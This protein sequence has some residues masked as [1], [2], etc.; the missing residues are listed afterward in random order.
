MRRILLSVVELYSVAI[1]GI[2]QAYV[3]WVA[4]ESATRIMACLR[5]PNYEYASLIV[6]GG[7]CGPGFFVLST[8]ELFSVEDT[9]FWARGDGHDCGDA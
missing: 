2:F 4:Q 5:L 1:P 8:Q 6:N 9:L 3:V 7:Q